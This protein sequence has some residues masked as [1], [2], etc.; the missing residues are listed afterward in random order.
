M[1]TKSYA[2]L[3][4]TE[5]AALACFPWIGKGDSKMADKAA[6]QAMREEL[7]V[8]DFSARV[9][10]GEGERDRAPRLHVG[11]LLGNE[12]ARAKY[13]PMSL[14]VDPVEGTELVARGEGGA[15][16]T[17]SIGS[18]G[19]LLRAPDMYMDKLAT[20]VAVAGLCLN[21]TVEENLRILSKAKNKP[22]EE[23]RVCIMDR[24]RNRNKIKQL[25][26]LKVKAILIREGDVSAC[27]NTALGDLDLYL[28][29]GAAPEGVISAA[30]LNCLGGTFLGKLICYTDQQ[31]EKA[32]E[33]DLNKV[34]SGKDLAAGSSAFIATGITT[35]DLLKGVESRDNHMKTYSLI[36]TQDRCQ[37]V[38]TKFHN[39]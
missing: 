25:R 13:M 35:G 20:G 2:L 1:L 4:A 26:A 11:E 15:I 38:E 33:L 18:Y 30:A 10:I 27:L 12:I 19:C 17:I 9:A 37:Y 29:V 39:R 8:M 3:K 22:I 7:Q 31:K 5:A 28:G 24:E 21:K 32:A 14:A 34:Y 23:M 16:S 36:I 6:V